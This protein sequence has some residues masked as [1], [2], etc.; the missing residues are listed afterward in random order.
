MVEYP[1]TIRKDNMIDD[2]HF[3]ITYYA[4]KHSKHISRRGKWDSMCRYFTTKLGNACVTYFD[5]DANN[6]RTASGNYKIRF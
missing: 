2:R 6:Y 5:L 4:K 3:T 1:I